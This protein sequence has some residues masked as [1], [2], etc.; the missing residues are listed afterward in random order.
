MNIVIKCFQNMNFLAKNIIK[1]FSYY[2]HN[3]LIIIK[4][5]SDNFPEIISMIFRKCYYAVWAICH[6]GCIT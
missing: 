1:T 6:I 2:L 5:Y 4:K 3:F